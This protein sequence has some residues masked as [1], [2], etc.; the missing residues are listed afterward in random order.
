[1]SDQKQVANLKIIPP[2]IVDDHGAIET[3][4]S[5]EAAAL[6]VEA[7]DVL[8]NE[9]LFYDST[10]RLLQPIVRGQNVSLIPTQSM[11]ESIQDFRNKLIRILERHHTEDVSALPL[12]TLVLLVLEGDKKARAASFWR[13]S[14]VALRSWVSGKFK[15]P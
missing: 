8:N 5:V 11:V 15:R 10:G 14:W 2:V 9:Y 1:M 3:Y 4:E 13:D 6:D 12:R 7:I